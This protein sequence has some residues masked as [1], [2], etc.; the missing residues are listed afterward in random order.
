MEDLCDEL[1]FAVLCY[2]VLVE[3]RIKVICANGRSSNVPVPAPLPLAEYS[4][5]RLHVGVDVPL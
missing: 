5:P 2:A 4:Y 3:A 1:C